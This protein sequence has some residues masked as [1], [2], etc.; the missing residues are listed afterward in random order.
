MRRKKS[1]LQFIK[2]TSGILSNKQI[3]IEI[4]IIEKEMLS[5]ATHFVPDVSQP[6]QIKSNFTSST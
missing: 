6:T 3:R 2:I 1:F 5:H 4:K